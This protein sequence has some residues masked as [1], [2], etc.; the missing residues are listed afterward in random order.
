MRYLASL[1][2]ILFS[3]GL[4]H[5]EWPLDKEEAWPLAAK[6]SCDC[7]PCTCNPLDCTCANCATGCKGKSGAAAAGNDVTYSVGMTEAQPQLAQ[8]PVQYQ[9]VCANGVCQLVPVQTAQT[10]PTLT[11]GSLCPCCGMA[12]TAEQAAKASQ[13]ASAQAQPMTYSSSPVVGAVTVSDSGSGGRNGIFAR[14]RA[15]RANRGS[16]GCGG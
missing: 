1:A 4:A 9:Q 14:W 16:G 8:A 5:A 10:R 2:L 11:A 12:M 13:C 3:V 6:K 15:R 7:N